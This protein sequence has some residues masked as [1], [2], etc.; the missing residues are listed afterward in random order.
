MEEMII[1]GNNI[2]TRTQIKSYLENYNNLSDKILENLD[3]K[4]DYFIIY[5]FNGNVINR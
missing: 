3:R 1:E 4:L 5:N 2:I